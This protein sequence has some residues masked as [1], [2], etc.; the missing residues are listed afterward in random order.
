M[1]RAS[2]FAYLR[3]NHNSVLG[4]R[5]YALEAGGAFKAVNETFVE[6]WAQVRCGQSVGMLLYTSCWASRMFR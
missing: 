2:T 1:C 6:H 5:E 3:E 4:M